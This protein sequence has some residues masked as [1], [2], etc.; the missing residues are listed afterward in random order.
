[1]TN[2]VKERAERTGT[3]SPEKPQGT[4][5]RLRE[6]ADAARTKASEALTSTRERAG[7]AYAVAKDQV[8]KTGE[9]ASAVIDES[10]MAAIVGGLALGA[11]VGALLPRSRAEEEYLGGVGER[12]NETGRKAAEAARDAGREKLDELGLN[13]DAAREQISKLLDSAVKAVSS[14]GD[15][16]REAVRK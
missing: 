4:A 11:L 8:S 14:A 3:A 5:A 15:A 6:T 9:R 7:S 13:R 1:M 2:S 12:I 16:A 10:P